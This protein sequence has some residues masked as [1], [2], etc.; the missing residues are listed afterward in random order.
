MDQEEKKR[1]KF[2]IR[3]LCCV[4]AITYKIRPSEAKLHPGGSANLHLYTYIPTEQN[5]S[6]GR[7]N[8]TANQYSYS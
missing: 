5:D 6:A 1:G 2:I 4:R 3:I 8:Q 7:A